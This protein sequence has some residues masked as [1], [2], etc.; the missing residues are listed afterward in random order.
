MTTTN[1][2]E[3]QEKCPA[4]GEPN[5]LDHALRTAPPKAEAQP[6]GEV[7]K[8]DFSCRVC[9]VE[10]DSAP[11]P[12]ARAVCPNCCEDHDYRYER[13]L[14]GHYCIHCGQEAPHD[15]FLED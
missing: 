2:P 12:P 3:A 11:D 7:E 4:C 5:C 9:G 15:Y 1:S 13:E 8:I 14:R 10:C 6:Q